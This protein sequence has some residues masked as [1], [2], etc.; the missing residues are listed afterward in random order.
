L[1]VACSLILLTAY[2]GETGSGALHGVQRGTSEI[3]NPVQEGA[4]RALKPIRDLFGWFGDTIAAKGQVEELRRERD[5]L[6]TEVLG[7]EFRAADYDH[8]SALL[9]LDGALGLKDLGPQT[10]RVIFQSP[11]VWYATIRVDKGSDDGVRLY[12]PVINEEALIGRVTEVFGGSAQVTL[13]TDTTTKVPARAGPR[14]AFGIV[15][16]S[17]A[18]NP[19][20]LVMTFTE[21]GAKLSVGDRVVTRG[22]EPEDRQQSLYPVGLPIGEI[23]R[24]DNEGTDTQEVHLRP[25]ADM[26]SLDFVQILTKPRGP[27]S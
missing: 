20:D 10:G 2:F 4:S 3:L 5:R 9:Q 13:I 7:N 8:L 26:R 19:T 6:R 12:Q 25:Y 22:T 15:E 27:G 21:P 24:I 1:L 16:P 14:G 11:T 18:G 17:S 23:K